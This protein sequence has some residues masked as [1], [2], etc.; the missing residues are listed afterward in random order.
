ML[1]REPA[2]ALREVTGGRGLATPLAMQSH[3]DPVGFRTVVDETLLE[4]GMLQGLLRREALLGI[5][6]K[7]PLQQVQE[8]AVEG[9]VDRDEFLAERSATS[10]KV[11]ENVHGDL[12]SAVSLP[13][14]ICAKPGSFQH[15]DSPACSG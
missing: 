8:L 13:A 2:K 3:A 1:S 10:S 5:V 9:G 12:R 11:S 14:R 15:S 4:P 6:D 7:D